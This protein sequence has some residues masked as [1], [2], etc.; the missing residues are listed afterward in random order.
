MR[1]GKVERGWRHASAAPFKKSARLSL[2][3]EGQVSSWFTLDFGA[4]CLYI[5]KPCK[6]VVSQNGTVAEE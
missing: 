2:S 5:L 4:E 3:P 6:A 1:T